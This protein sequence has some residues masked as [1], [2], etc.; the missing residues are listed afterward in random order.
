MLKDIIDD[1]RYPIVFIG[2]GMSKRYLKDYPTWVELLKGY[3]SQIEE[4]LNFYTYLRNIKSELDSDLTEEEKDF[5][6]NIKAASYIN[7]KFDDL[8][9]D[10]KFELPGLTIEKAYNENISPFK[11]DLSLK[12]KS[13]ELIEDMKDELES[14]KIF[15]SKARVIVTTNYDMLTEKL[16]EEL[17][18]KP[19]IYVGQNGFFEKTIDW[20]ELYKIH[21][22]VNKPNSLII[23][24]EDY[25]NYDE[26]SILISAKILSNMI[27]TPIIFLGYSLT[28]RNVRKLLSDFSSQLPN[29]DIRKK[30]K[31]II[32]VEYL[33]HE[34]KLI[35][36]MNRDEILDIDFI[37]IST[38][39]YM[40]LF[41][42]LSKI[43][44][45]LTP[46]E[47]LRYERAIKKLV[48]AAGAEGALETV[49]ISPDELDDL[50]EK[51]EQGKPIVV[52]LGDKK[53]I[54]VNPDLIS[55]LEDYLF[56]KN[57]IL[58]HVALR[59]VAKE[60]SNSRIPF[61][62]YVNNVDLD[63][64]GLREREILKIKKRIRDFSSFSTLQSSIK[65]ADETGDIDLILD[66]S[67][68]SLSKKVDL[69]AYSILH[70]N[71]NRVEEFIRET[72]FPLFKEEYNKKSSNIT[73]NL[74]KLFLA[75]DILINGQFHN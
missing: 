17:D 7:K 45:G 40:L 9:Y 39:N 44:E 71:K 29:E 33:E 19:T 59:F 41:D 65:H 30:S 23:N 74:R 54:F 38:D 50:E 56:N 53:F 70:L 66:N 11:Y 1:N 69:I 58:P 28:D 52:A 61:L 47:I 49:L 63:K 24:E 2:S 35:E 4:E 8:Y 16:L 3:W 55:Y 6:V 26:N 21:G 73:S 32:I 18:S 62:K 14:Y 72:A 48:V 68:Y 60:Q 27:E 42:R 67:N 12:F 37:H 5:L 75:Y 34:K 31:R 25:N 64:L 15:L 46:H 43:N 20:S 36:Q 51:I 10:E 13:Y 57:S 22:D